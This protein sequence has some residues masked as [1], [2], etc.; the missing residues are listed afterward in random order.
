ME[1]LDYRELVKNV[2]QQY[3]SE[4]VEADASKAQIV[5]D[6]ERDRYLLL[7]NATKAK[8]DLLKIVNALKFG[9]Y[10]FAPRPIIALE[11]WNMDKIVSRN[12]N[13]QAAITYWD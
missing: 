12:G 10:A 8:L 4:K 11:W 7:L 2:I 6:T 3:A 1:K 9:E 13:N 5:F